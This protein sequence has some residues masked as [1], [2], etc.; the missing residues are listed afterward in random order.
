[1]IDPTEEKKKYNCVCAIKGVSPGTERREIEEAFARF[2]KIEG[3]FLFEAKGYA[4]I[5]FKVG[6]TISKTFNR[7]S[8]RCFFIY[9]LRSYRP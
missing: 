2:G 8:L 1:M 4:Y 6:S 7:G 5:H 3:I 9:F